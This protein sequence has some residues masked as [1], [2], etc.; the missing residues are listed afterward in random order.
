MLGGMSDL[1]AAVRRLLESVP[2]LQPGMNHT[3]PR[4]FER[5][6][7]AVGADPEKTQEVKLLDS[8]F[9]A[10]FSVLPRNP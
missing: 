3:D 8:P 6:C 10:G 1:T 7:L 4:T 9:G 2:T 5:V